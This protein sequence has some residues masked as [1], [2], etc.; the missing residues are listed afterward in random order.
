[1]NQLS[2]WARL[3]SLKILW[4]VELLLL[5]LISVGCSVP[6]QTEKKN[7]Q[8][9][10]LEAQVLQIIRD[11]PE[12]VIESLQ[13]YQQK[14]Q[15]QQQQQQSF[16][17]QMQTNS[18][19]VIGTSP[20]TGATETKVVLIEFSDFQCP[21]CAQAQ[22][23]LKQFMTKHQRQVK[24]VYKHLPLTK[25]HPEAMPAAKAAWA[26]GQQEKFWQYHD[27]L[28]A[29]QD[30]LGEEFYTSTAK[31]LNL[32]LKRFNGDR[33]SE[34]A[35]AAIEKD[36]QLAESLGVGGTPFFVMNGVAASGAIQLSDLEKLL[37]RVNKE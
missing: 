20:T 6:F 10:E 25:I 29:N 24:L 32:D 9:P 3:R 17:Q 21:Y 19:A 11:H 7:S 35:S 8:N 15:Q 28:F 13:A 27:A 37:V 33:N 14:Q 16:L 23:T 12:V 31:G 2:L 1:M 22:E 30:K 5:C 4:R 26:A 34:A 18:Q 36:I